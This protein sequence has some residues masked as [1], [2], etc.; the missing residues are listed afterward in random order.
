MSAETAP[1]KAPRPP[2]R[3][4]DSLNNPHLHTGE[5]SGESHPHKRGEIAEK[6]KRGRPKGSKNKTTLLQEAIKN[7]FTRLARRRSRA[8]FE[9]LTEEAMNGE[10]WAIKL[11]MDKIIPNASNEDQVRTGDFGITINISPME[12][13][14]VIIDAEP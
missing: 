8:I 11:F 1:E 6:G 14:K 3:V 7:D 2:V 9:K 12:K 5:E 4:D 13:E 10:A